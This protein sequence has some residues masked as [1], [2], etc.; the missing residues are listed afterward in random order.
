[1]SAVR[2]KIG[3]DDIR[4]LCDNLW[5]RNHKFRRLN[6]IY[7]KRMALIGGGLSLYL[8]W[9]F[10]P[11]P[12]FAWSLVAVVWLTLISIEC[13][14]IFRR[15]RNL[16]NV[17]FQRLKGNWRAE[18]RGDR[19][20]FSRPAEIDTYERDQIDEVVITDGRLLVITDQTG[21]V[22]PLKNIEKTRRD[23]FLAEIGAMTG[24]IEIVEPIT[25]KAA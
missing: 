7:L 12:K 1:M 10:S 2:F 23:Q 3:E 4:V 18:M 21:R 8:L 14:M 6:P 25:T 5:I 22:I 20:V 9:L 17:Y 19:L 15:E 24:P 16:R 11:V 13:F